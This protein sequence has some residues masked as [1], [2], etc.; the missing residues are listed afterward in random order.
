MVYM[1]AQF[2]VLTR[3]QA[4]KMKNHWIPGRGNR[5]VLFFNVFTLVD[6]SHLLN[7]YWEPLTPIVKQLKLK[8]TTYLH[9]VPRL[10][11]NGSVSPQLP[12]AFMVCREIILPLLFQGI[13]SKNLL[14]ISW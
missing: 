13:F 4:G 11:M 14:V 10:R 5:I 12:Y 3:L 1:R 9:L 2:S 8:F 6:L 7:G